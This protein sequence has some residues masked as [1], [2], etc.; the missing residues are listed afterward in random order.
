MTV[1]VQLP[2]QRLFTNA[3]APSSGAKLYVYDAGTSTPRAVYTTSALSVTRTQPVT[4]DAYGNWLACWIDPAGGNY[5]ISIYD[6][7]NA[8]VYTEDNI[9]VIS[10][11]RELPAGGS[12]GEVLAKASGTDY[13]VAW[14]NSYAPDSSEFHVGDAA[15][16]YPSIASAIAAVNA[17]GGWSG[18]IR[19]QVIVHPGYYT[20]TESVTVPAWGGIKGTSKGL[21][22]FYN[23]T[24]DMFVVGNGGNVF[25]EDF[26]VEG[27]PTTTIAAFNCNNQDS[28]HVRN[29]DMLRNGGNCKQKFVVQSGST[30]QILFVENCIIDWQ[31]TSGYCN[32]LTN[33]DSASRLNDV[34]FNDCF[35]D[36]Y[37]LTGY[38][39]SI[40]CDGCNDVRIKRSTIR[41]ASTWNTG[42]RWNAGSGISGTKKCEI[43]NSDL[44]GGVPTYNESGTTIVLA[45]TDS[46]GSATAGT[47]TTRNSSIT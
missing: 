28:V 19:Y 33:T 31:A 27:A 32:V 18:S 38:G 13:D 46:V 23:N 39:G 36:A 44:S 6:S 5:K 4:A 22:Q 47:L 12:A 45:N 30:W 40:R 24:T 26:L 14:A 16:M 25:F 20:M 9:A 11:E 15:W 34:I 41:G 37:E 10:S 2:R 1:L 43:Y 21:V 42:V 35:F 29:V 3:G 7:G 17:T 8:L